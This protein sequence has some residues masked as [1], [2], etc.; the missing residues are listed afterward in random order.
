VLTIFIPPLVTEPDAVARAIASVAPQA[1]GKPILGIF[2]RAEGAPAALASIPSYAFP[3]SAARALARVTHY[4]EWRAKAGGEVA[5]FHDLRTDDLRTIVDEVLSRGGGWVTTDEAR[6]LLAAAGIS[7]AATRAVA[8]ADEAV[9]AAE[10]VG[11]PVVLKAAGPVLL[12]KTE[13]NAV[14]LN[15]T[16]EAAV[17]AVARQFEAQFKGEMSG[18]VVQRMVPGGVEMLVGAI[19][20]PTFGPIVVCGS[21]GVLVELLGDTAFRLHPVTDRDAEDM[22]SE[23]KG[24]ALLRGFRGAPPA[25][26]AALRETI[27]RVS[28]VLSVCPEIQELDLNPVKV[29]RTGVC[30]VDARVRIDRLRLAPRTRRVEY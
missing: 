12:H 5:G 16:D 7:S 2:M 29:L 1:Q 24:A 3:E 26:E 30:V 25:D 4:G 8:T 9:A 21:G 20:D 17:R 13:R 11:Y 22:V 18:M 27:L 10:Q 19:E 15:L 14:R 6:R 23:L 28:A